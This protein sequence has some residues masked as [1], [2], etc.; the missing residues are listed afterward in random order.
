MMDYAPFE[1]PPRTLVSGAKTLNL[2]R[3]RLMGILNP[4]PDSFSDGSN[5]FQFEDGMSQARKIIEDGADWLD[6]GGESSGPDS[7]EVPLEEELRRVIP[8]I[9]AIRKES[10]IWISVDTWK[11]EVARKSLEAGADAVN[12]VSALRADKEMAG[13]IAQYQAPVVMMYS[14]DASPRT[15]RDQTEYRDVLDTLR[16]FFSER[17]KYAESLGIDRSQIVIDPGMGFFISGHAKYS[18]EVI[19]RISE[20]H[21]FDLPLLLGPSRKSFLAEVSNGRRLSF[22][23]R[24]IPC[25]LVSGIALWQ[26]V[27]VLRVHEIQQG[28]LL[29]DTFEALAGRK[30][31]DDS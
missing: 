23:E 11:A 30:S 9:Q 1:L 16:N 15:T 27:S 26:G 22:T 13:V 20:L 19:R 10:D 4:T 14:K 8:L 21:E 29:I 3:P 17:I 28:R 7:M 5:F 2:D 31:L 18:F 6:I 24:D 25:A 12:D